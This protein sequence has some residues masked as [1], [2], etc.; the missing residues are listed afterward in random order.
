MEEKAESRLR[1]TE[2]ECEWRLRSVDREK[3]ALEEAQAV[4]REDRASLRDRQEQ[5]A[6]SVEAL[7]EQLLR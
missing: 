6:G 5:S 7:K 2:M 1:E 4:L 3:R